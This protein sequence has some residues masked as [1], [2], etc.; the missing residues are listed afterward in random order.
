MP[1]A[2]QRVTGFI[3]EF[4]RE[5]TGTHTGGIGLE[6]SPD[7]VYLVR[8]HTQT[9]ANTAGGGIRRAYIGICT[10]V[11]VEERTLGS[12][13]QHALAL[14]KGLVDFELGIGKVELAHILHTLEPGAF[15]VG[16]VVVGE[17]K[18][19]QNLLMTCFE[20]LVLLKE[21][22]ED[23][24]H[25]QSHTSSLIRIGRSDS[26]AGGS[27]LVLAFGSLIGTVEHTVGG[28]NKVCTAADVQAL[29]Q[30]V[31]SGLQLVGLLH[32]EVRCDDAAIAYDVQ[33]ILVEN[34]GGNAAEHELFAFKYDGMSGIGA[35]GKTGDHIIAR[36]KIVDDFA[37]S[38]VAENDAEQGI[39]FSL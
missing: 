3:E 38:F 21:I 31:A 33:L 28:K 15:L 7:T 32:E 25:T 34:T 37:F 14:S 5:R 1:D 26:L 23:I 6:D 20:T 35:T 27:H 36:S 4:H 16:N 10:M 12:F 39:D 11:D 9:G 19:A 17:M 8:S 22:V 2:T 13:C 18:V 30:A 29:R 24:T